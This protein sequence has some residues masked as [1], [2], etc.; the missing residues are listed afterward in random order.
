MASGLG[1]S[2]WLV[3]DCLLPVHLYL[4]LLLTVFVYKSPFFGKDTSHIGLGPLL[5][6]SL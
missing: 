6:T 4:A 5:Q 2:L 3:G 1:L